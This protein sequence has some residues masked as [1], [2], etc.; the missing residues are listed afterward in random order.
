MHRL[1]QRCT[2]SNPL[3]G[4]AK[5]AFG[6]CVT[7]MCRRSS[8][9]LQVFYEEPEMRH[10]LQSILHECTLHTGEHACRQ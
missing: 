8:S 1:R 9:L 10:S 3:R 4:A 2:C 5:N 7:S 6:K